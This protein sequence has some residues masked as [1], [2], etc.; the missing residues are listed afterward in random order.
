LVTPSGAFVP[1]RYWSQQGTY[2]GI[3]S[4]YYT[5]GHKQML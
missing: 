5:V 3:I 1:A 4:S 2:V